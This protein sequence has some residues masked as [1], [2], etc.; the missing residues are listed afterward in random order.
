MMFLTSSQIRRP[1]GT[2]SSLEQPW[3]YAIGFGL[4]LLFVGSSG[5][6]ADPNQP[7]DSVATSEGPL[8]IHP[9][10]HASLALL[11]KGK[12]ILVDP[13]GSVSLYAGLPK[14]DLILITH[15]HSDHFNK[16]T[17]AGL[18]SPATVLV[19]PPTVFEQ[20]PADLRPRTTTLTNGQAYQVLDLG[21]AA[22]PAYNTTTVRLNFHPKGRDNGY[23]LTLG[24][25]RVYLSG[26]TEDTPEMRGLKD[27]DLA[28]VC[29][30]LPYT[31]EV[32]QA[33]QAVR[34]FHPKVVYPYHCRNSNLEEFK[35]LVGADP[36]IEVRL[37]NWYASKP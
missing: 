5:W 31:M 2:T 37:R 19:A 36:T 4:A 26:D 33:A 12:T 21:I 13:V 10:N 3:R 18:T 6:A 17:L 9:I 20:M 8:A 16:D 14:P 23:V 35:K 28:F 30:N 27:I 7:G 34:T 29:M 32:P 11:W 15:L 24:G 1:S 22:V 25:K